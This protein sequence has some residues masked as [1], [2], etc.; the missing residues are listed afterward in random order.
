MNHDVTEYVKTCKECGA[1][2]PQGPNSQA[3]IFTRPSATEPFVHIETDIKGPVPRSR[4]GYNSILLREDRLSKFAEMC[5][6]RDQGTDQVCRELRKWIGRYGVPLKL[7]SGNGPCFISTEFQNFLDRY[8]IEH[9]YST[10]YRPQANG[11]VEHLNR[12]IMGT[13]LS[14]PVTMNPRDWPDY[15]PEV[16][17]AYNVSKHSSIKC[18]PYEVVFKEKPRTTI[19]QT[20]E[21]ICPQVTR[22]TGDTTKDMYKDIIENDTQA[23][24]KR[25]SQHNKGIKFSPF[26]QGQIVKKRNPKP[27]TFAPRWFGPYQIIRPTTKNSTSYVIKKPAGSKEEIV[28][29]NNLKPFEERKKKFKR[30]QPRAATRDAQPK[31]IDTKQN[32]DFSE[33]S[34]SGE[35]EEVANEEA[36]SGAV[37][38]RTIP[39]SPKTGTRLFW[40]FSRVLNQS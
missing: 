36:K 27:K 33:E 3:P 10:A 21:E 20:A 23:S 35:E 26:C 40:W 32:Q 2:N 1:R 4:F 12:T 5:P 18:S 14:K 37:A 25:Q 39:C 31:F 6:L 34:S 19:G 8:G 9:S 38:E 30:I 24:L 29:F 16:Q 17:L 11:S 13:M 7:H 15:L 28:H 22:E